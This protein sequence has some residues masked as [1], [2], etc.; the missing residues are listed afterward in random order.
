MVWD[1]LVTMMQPTPVSIARGMSTRTIQACAGACRIALAR[2]DRLRPAD[3]RYSLRAEVRPTRRPDDRTPFRRVVGVRERYRDRAVIAGAF[4][5][6]IDTLQRRVDRWGPS[7]FDDG[8]ASKSWAVGTSTGWST[9]GGDR[10]SVGGRYTIDREATA[11]I[12][13]RHL[14]SRTAIGMAEIAW[15]HGQDWRFSLGYRTVG[16][17]ALSTPLER[18]ID[19]VNGAG[20]RERGMQATVSTSPMTMGNRGDLA[21][22]AQVSQATVAADEIARGTAPAGADRG[23][24]MF[25]HARF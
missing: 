4:D 8:P 1:V 16:G 23:V 2:T 22:G 10:L 12:T 18:G 7:S 6:S 3:A 17:G 5:W 14:H 21:I 11:V 20:L 15:D 24:S 9:P 13:S 19:I 25:L